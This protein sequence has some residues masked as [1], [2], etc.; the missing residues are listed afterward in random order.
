MGWIVT[1][2]SNWCFRTFVINCN[3]CI[4]FL[5]F[6]VFFRLGMI[7]FSFIF[8][9][10]KLYYFLWWKVTLWIVGAVHSHALKR[11]QKNPSIDS[12]AIKP[13]LFIK[14]GFPG[15]VHTHEK[16]Q[17][18]VAHPASVFCPGALKVPTQ[19][20]SCLPDAALGCLLKD[21]EDGAA[22]FTLTAT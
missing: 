6:R 12:S 4:F 15:I 9:M 13:T 17:Q 22:V 2:I 20:K 7:F 11:D 5:Q 16:G 3:F 19:P 18:S 21:R 8:V 10:K 1:C 14:I